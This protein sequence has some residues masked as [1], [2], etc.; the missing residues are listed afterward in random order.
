MHLHVPD[1]LVRHGDAAF[2]QV[3]EAQEPRYV[4]LRLHVVLRER[5]LP[6]DHNSWGQQQVFGGYLIVEIVGQLVH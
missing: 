4:I 1:S 5:G 3:F 6:Y 2:L